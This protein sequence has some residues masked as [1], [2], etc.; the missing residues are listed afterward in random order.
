MKDLNG[1]PIDIGDIV[2]VNIWGAEKKY[3]PVG[4][5]LTKHGNPITGI[6]V[7][8]QWLSSGNTSSPRPIR[9]LVKMEIED[10]I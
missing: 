4:K 6:K 5:I 8:I 2:R 1:T 7:T 10:L 9:D 3:H